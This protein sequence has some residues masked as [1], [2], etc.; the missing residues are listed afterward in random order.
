MERA[1]H[2]G[3]ILHRVGEHNQLHAAGSVAVRRRRRD[4]LDSLS[5][6]AHGIHVNARARRRHIDRRADALR[7]GKCFRKRR[8]ESPIRRGHALLHQCRVAADVVDTRFLR[9]GIHRARHDNRVAACGGNQACR[10]HRDALVDDWNTE[11]AL[12][13]FSG[14]DQILC[15]CGDAVIDELI[16]L[17]FIGMRT[18]I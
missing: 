15:L 5:A 11:F 18:G 16:K 8:D 6:K 3:V 7:R 13:C 2:E 17:L 1:R 14:F 12:Q 10:R 9:G 4:I